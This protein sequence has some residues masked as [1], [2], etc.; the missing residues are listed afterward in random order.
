[1]KT[2]FIMIRHGFSEA[3]RE[4]RFAGHSDFPLTDL[5]KIQAEKCSEALR[6]EKIDAIYASDLSRAFETAVPVAKA[7]NLPV[8]PHEGLR[9]IF[10]GEWEGKTFEELDRCYPES[11]GVWKTDLGHAHPDGG[12]S[13]AEIFERIITTLGEI[14]KENEGKTICIATHA[15]PIRAVC[16]AAI[17]GAPEDM[18]KLTWMPNASLNL[19]EY[20]EGSF[21]AIYTGRIDHLGDLSTFLPNNV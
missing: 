4:H 14:A 3:N 19:F 21:K 5:G 7:H 13:V 17:G 12:E 20:E 2:R 1:M 11:F 9:E 16:T 10:A 6:D 8:I 15:T 18:S